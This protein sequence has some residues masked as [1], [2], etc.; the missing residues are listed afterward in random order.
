MKRNESTL[1]RI[2]R[3]IIGIAALAV[4]FVVVGPLKIV[5][6]VVAVIALFTALT[7]FCLL[8]KLF[9]IS[10]CECEPKQ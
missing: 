8:Y 4:S 9:G 1:D 10:T 6:I 5:L 3:I 7:G 2:I